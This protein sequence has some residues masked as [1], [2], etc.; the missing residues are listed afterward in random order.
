[1]NTLQEEIEAR[2]PWYHSIELEPGIRT[3]GEPYEPS[4]NNTRL[5]RKKLD[6]AGKSV[7]D[8]A[9]F[10][11]MW[12]F[13]AERLGAS[14]VLATDC[15]WRENPL[16]CQRT[17]GSKVVFLLN[18]PPHEV[19]NRLDSF[20]RCNDHWRQE[21][22][23]KFDIVQHLGLFYHLRDPLQSLLQA[24]SILKDGGKL[25][26]ESAAMMN[27]PRNVMAFNPYPRWQIYDDV[28]TWWAPSVPCLKE[29]LD[30][31]LFGVDDSEVSVIEQH[32]G[33]GRVALI[34]TSKPIEQCNPMLVWELK[35]TYRTPG[36]SL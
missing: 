26:F 9:T 32:N 2:R 22:G 16:F 11:G 27:E 14:F 33:F 34:A 8:L 19:V 30:R 20:L 13:E 10:D 3:P 23:L 28:T 18:V 36:L 24:R 31:S 29:L 35:N 1:M 5:V 15:M 4:W 17:L 25:L 7:C 21:K 12:A 6:Y